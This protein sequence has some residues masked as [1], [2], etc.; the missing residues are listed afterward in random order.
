[1]GERPSWDEYFMQIAMDVATRSTCLRRQVGAVIVRDRRILTT[2]YNGAPMGLPH[3]LTVGCH[4]VNGHCIRCLHAEQN[5]IIQG[6]YFG[7]RTDGSVLY[8]THQPCNMCAKMIVN[9]GITK[10]FIGGEYPDEFALEVLRTAGVP[11][12]LV[13]L[14]SQSRE[15]VPNDRADALAAVENPL[16]K[17]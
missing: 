2:G 5:A 10:V 3:C 15:R 8:C 12:E 4:L 9:A 13:A 7:V 11:L 17:E 6:A 14:P 16:D 1:M